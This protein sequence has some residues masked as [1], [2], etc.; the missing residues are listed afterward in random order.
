MRTIEPYS[1]RRTRTGNLLLF[2][3][4]A[5][6]AESR[7]YRVDRITG[8]KVTRRPFTPR[9]AIEL[10]EGGPLAV[11]ALKRRTRRE[12]AQSAAGLARAAQYGLDR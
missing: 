10:T 11:P 7:S 8:A 5:D 4:K 3:V 9:F 12:L 1:L 6:T 2:A